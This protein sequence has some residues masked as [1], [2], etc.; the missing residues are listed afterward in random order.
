MNA[1]IE[2]NLSLILFF[3]WFAILGV[4]FWVYP[5]S[6][7][8]LDVYKR[9]PLGCQGRRKF[10]AEDRAE[11]EQSVPRYFCENNRRSR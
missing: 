5:V 8:H 11:A 7:T 3:P 4:L 6:Y 10:R 2:V 1:Q 9:Q